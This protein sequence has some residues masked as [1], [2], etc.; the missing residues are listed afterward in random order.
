MT[1]SNDTRAEWT[2][3]IEITGG[4]WPERIG[5]R[6]S[7]VRDPGDGIYPFD[8]H[9]PGELIVKLDDDPLTPNTR[10]WT[11]A[12]RESNVRYLGSERRD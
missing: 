8:K 11:C 1:D 9:A 3:R 6:G 7:V 10:T 4:P 5:C 12:I 2:P